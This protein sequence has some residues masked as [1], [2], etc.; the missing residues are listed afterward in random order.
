MHGIHTLGPSIT[1]ASLHAALTVLLLA[2]GAA[3]RADSSLQ[4]IAGSGEIVTACLEPQH[5][6]WLLLAP[7]TPLPAAPQ[8]LVGAPPGR[9]SETAEFTRVDLRTPARLLWTLQWGESKHGWRELQ[10]PE[11]LLGILTTEDSLPQ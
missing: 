10:V 5:P 2:P 1:R 11:A 3:V 7:K 8:T 4:S 6:T 9:R